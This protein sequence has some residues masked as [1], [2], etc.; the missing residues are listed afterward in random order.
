MAFQRV[1][2]AILFVVTILGNA[3]AQETP[4]P[5]SIGK[6]PKWCAMEVQEVIPYRRRSGSRMD[7]RRR[8]T[9]NTF[10]CEYSVIPVYTTAYREVSHLEYTCCDDSP[11]P[12][13]FETL[14]V[15]VPYKGIQ[16]FADEYPV[17]PLPY[18]YDA[19]EPYIDEKT[20]RVHHLGHHAGYTR[21][22]NAA[23][24]KWRDEVGPGVGLQSNSI[25]H[26]LENLD[27]I[28]DKHRT[29]I[30]NNGGGFV[31]H[32]I[33]WA[34]MSP[35]GESEPPR[36]PEATLATE[37]IANF[38][39][40]S[41]FQ[42]QFTN[43]AKTLFG[44]GYVWLSRNPREQTLIIHTTANQ[45]SPISTGLRPILVIDI[46]EHAYYLK[47]QNKRPDHIQDWWALVDWGQVKALSDWWA[48]Y[49]AGHD[50]L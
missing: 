42:E 1:F 36:L 8:C 40:F 21:K 44:S 49:D 35:R 43:T 33:Y 20:A 13:P 46:W 29:A 4:S 3:S 10:C 15:D 5:P 19:L 26:I 38:H 2:F 9:W 48:A 11:A 18:E 16:L 28:P 27:Q 7:C 14:S 37:I 17:P 50:E 47:H 39:N 34:T 22:M 24:K 12:C 23:L 32:A 25:L 30:R 41:N 6:Q 31:N 45:D